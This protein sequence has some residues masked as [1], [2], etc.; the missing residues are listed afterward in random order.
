[1][2]S[3][4]KALL[5]TGALVAASLGGAASA[6]AA[7]TAPPTLV[8]TN[9]ACS[10]GVCEVGPGDVGVSFAAGMYGTGGPT[11]TPGPCTNNNGA[12]FVMSVVSGSLPPGLQ[13]NTTFNEYGDWAIDGTPTQAGTYAFTLQITPWNSNEGGI[14]GPSGTQQLTITVGTG[15]SDRAQIRSATWN[16][17]YSGLAISG[18]DAN[19]GALWS[20]SVT[21]TG[22]VLISNQRAAYVAF[23][24]SLVLKTTT[25]YPCPVG[26]CDLTVTNNL[27]STAT[28]FLGKPIY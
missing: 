10:N 1:M 8:T 23:D 19:I 7:T 6:A 22:R 27:G 11:C 2:R 15:H 17:H 4:L 21:S 9:F 28:V 3:P 5:V 16:E 14:V 18:W 20:V 24:G 25:G 26:G 12:C 13:L